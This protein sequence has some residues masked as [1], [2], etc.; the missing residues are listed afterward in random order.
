MSFIFVLDKVS[1]LL[2]FLSLW[3]LFLLMKMS[4]KYKKVVFSYL[5][6]KMLRIILVLFLLVSFSFYR[7][8]GFYVFFEVSLL[9]LIFIILGWGYQVERLQ[10]SFYLFIYTIFGSMPFLL[11]I[12]FLDS[13]LLNTT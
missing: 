9:P 5:R 6:F 1:F 10:A 11:V 4:L 13:A 3:M 12:F 2:G 8:L 7:V